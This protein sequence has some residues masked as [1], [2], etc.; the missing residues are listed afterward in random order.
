MKVKSLAFLLLLFCNFCAHSQYVKI[1]YGVVSS[2][3]YNN[4]KLPILNERVNAQ[5]IFVGVDFPEK[6]CGYFSSQIGFMR[7]GGK[8]DAAYE[9]KIDPIAWPE[10]L[11]YL[12]LNTTYRFFLVHDDK[13]N[14]FVGIGPFANLYVKSNRVIDQNVNGSLKGYSIDKVHGAAVAQL[15]AQ[16]NIQKVRLGFVGSYQYSLSPILH[17]DFLNLKNNV[18]SAMLSLGYKIGDKNYN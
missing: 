12:S 4:K 11:S 3:F 15:G 16:V 14:I 10:T 13:S 6:K 8:Y 5:S 1:D 2:S 7:I 9:S 17:S 18:F